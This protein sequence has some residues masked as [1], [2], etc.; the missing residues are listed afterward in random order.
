MRTQLLAAELAVVLLAGCGPSMTDLD[1]LAASGRISERAPVRVHLQA[2]IAAPPSKVWALLINAPAWP[3]WDSDV[4]GVSVKQPLASGTRFDWK[5][6]NST[7]HSEVRFFEP[8]QRIIWTGKILTAKAIHAWAL[9]PAPGGHT[10]VVTDESMDGPLMATLFPAEKLAAA[11]SSWL[12]ALK[13][14]AEKP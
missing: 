8:G 3:S 6:G 13:K 11:D 9:M 1:Q 7:I 10:L 5:A 14:A 2:D 4:S 12:T